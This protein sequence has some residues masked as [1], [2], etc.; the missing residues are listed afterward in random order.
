MI[1][2]DPIRST[3]TRWSRRL[4]LVGLVIGLSLIL[5]TVAQGATT[6]KVPAPV[7]ASARAAAPTFSGRLGRCRTKRIS[8]RAEHTSAQNVAKA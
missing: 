8:T 4:L 1:K 2:Q 3:R 7:L 6:H 5:A